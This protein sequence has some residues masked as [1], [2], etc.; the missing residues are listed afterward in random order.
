MIG[1][2]ISRYKILAKLGEGGMGVVYKAQD[3]KLDRPVALKFL[4]AH[5]LGNEEVR[6][7]FHREA[8][9]AAAL[10][11]PNVCTVFEID[12]ADDQ[13]FIAM[14]LI[15]GESLDEKIARGPLPL[16]EALAIA[17]QI[18]EGLQAAH[19]RGV[20]HRD[21]KP[22]NILVDP[23]GHVTIMDFGLAQLQQASR[24]TKA[25]Q[26]LGTTTYMSP[27]QAQG[28]EVD[29]RT[30]VWALGVVLY[31]MLVGERPFKG[32]YDSAILYSV[33]NEQPEPITALRTGVP[34]ELEI[35]VGKCLAKGAADRY[36]N[37]SDLIVDLRTL[38]VKLKS[39]RSTIIPS[40]SAPSAPDTSTSPTL[41]SNQ[42][43]LLGV[44]A[45]VTLAL[46][47]VSF[48]Y[49]NQTPPPDLPVVELSTG[50]L[51]NGGRPGQL[52]VSP[53]GRHLAAAEAPPGSLWVRSLDSAEWRE[54]EGTRGARYPFWSPDSAQIGYFADEKLRRVALA[55][56]PPQ[57]IAEAVDGRGGSWN[58]EDTI[59]FSPVPTG[60]IYSVSARGGDPVPITKLEEGNGL[61]RFPSFLPDGRRFLYHAGRAS[62]EIG[63]IRLGSLDGEVHRRLL[64]DRSNAVFSPRRFGGSAGS[65]L[66]VREGTL[67]AQPLDLSTLELSGGPVA[68]PISPPWGGNSGFFGF[69][70]S[71]AGVLSYVT[72]G[73]NDRQLV[74]VD[75]SGNVV[76]RTGVDVGGVSMALSPD[77]KQVAYAAEE[78]GYPDVWVFDLVRKTRTRLSQQPG[79]E[80]KPIWSPDG[81]QV[82]FRSAQAGTSGNIVLAQADGSRPPV[83]LISGLG[84][85]T[86][87]A[88]SHD[89]KFIV[90]TSREGE[91]SHDIEF[92][93]RRA[94]GDSGEPHKF[95]D[96]PGVGETGARLS[97]DSRYIAYESDES[98]QIEIYVQPF[99]NGGRKTTISSGGGEK[100]RWSRDG[101]ELY[102]VGPG[103][104]FTAVEV[105]TEGEFSMGASEILFRVSPG[106]LGVNY[107]VT[108][109]RDRFLFTEAPGGTGRTMKASVFAVR[110]IV[111]WEEKFLP[112]R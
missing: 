103:G 75:R 37:A 81:S 1:S 38:S 108:L 93:E 9:S 89:G 45:A 76:E 61:H 10:S 5:L 55:G 48:A 58:S 80:Y 72:A 12:E 4:P 104:A 105:S 27:E 42:H 32:E 79:S 39:G 95:T 43:P 70:V 64:P 90:Y 41:R 107:D 51:P 109:D 67:M 68:L 22:E 40:A 8:K 92:L 21:V 14:E 23:K 17:Q 112:E 62:E 24:L 73:S 60:A 7:R 83:A 31:E 59:L 3:T 84:E 69:S 82:A 6:K 86:P 111:N 36:Q 63:G 53:D 2:T 49:F 47:A 98:G 13:T 71:D 106:P 54:L 34:M 102:Y 25:D 74:R 110:T 100:P 56:G 18:A 94:D 66:F 30:D 78:D 19:D 16:D 99:P 97:L 52:S 28:A 15:E 77:G 50:P 85:E 33:L 20:I 29:H 88:W 96:T 46:L 26:T 91:L 35:C 87:Y 57:T 11:H 101:K 44:L 65:I